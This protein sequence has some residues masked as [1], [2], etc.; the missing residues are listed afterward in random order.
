MD[1]SIIKRKRQCIIMVG[2]SGSGKSTRAKE[3][4]NEIIN[5]NPKYDA[6]GRADVVDII[7]SDSIREELLGNENDQT[8]NGEVFQEVYKRMRYGIEH[9]HHI[10]IDATNLSL[11]DRRSFHNTFNSVHSNF[12]KYYEKIAYVMTT[13]YRESLERN[14]KRERV[15]PKE[16]LFRQVKK[17]EIPFYEEGFDSIY[18]DGEE[19]I[20][21]NEW[22]GIS[23]QDLAKIEKFM[24]GVNQKT[25]HHKYTLDIHCKKCTEEV[26]KRTNDEV[27]I[28]AAR[29]HDFGKL[30]TA[31]P[32]NDGSGDYRYYSHHNVGTFQLLPML[33]SIAFADKN[34][35]LELLFY[36]NYHMQP[37]FLNTE[38]SKEKWKNI[39]GEEKYNNLIMFN[40]CDKIASGTYQLE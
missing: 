28:R 13:S 33:N 26:M 8:N 1:Y 40:E 24:N 16:V 3:L 35:T 21:N 32:K 23:E 22:N 38:K 2:I 36:I 15:V 14:N 4:A 11:K 18:L 31:E 12:T 5:F 20:F 19:K 7:S 9:Y 6:L 30:F 29:I 25:H 39:F 27:L 10:I 34:K 17:F 37:F